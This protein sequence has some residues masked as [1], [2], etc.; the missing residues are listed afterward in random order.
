MFIDKGMDHDSKTITISTEHNIYIDDIPAVDI[1]N[2]NF[3]I[4]SEIKKPGID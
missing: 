2:E 1:Q 4:L 3:D